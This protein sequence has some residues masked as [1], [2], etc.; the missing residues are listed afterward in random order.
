MS[1]IL[2]IIFTMTCLVSMMAGHAEALPV[3]VAGDADS[4]TAPAGMD[5]LAWK[6]LLAGEI[7]VESVRTD[8]AGGAARVKALS[9]G[10]SEALWAVIISCEDAFRFV[11]GM[12]ICNVL[13]DDGGHALVHQG[14]KQSWILPRLDFTFAAIRKPFTAI[15]FQ[16][17]EGDLRTMEGGWRFET[18]P[19]IDAVI[20]THEIRVVPQFPAPR[21][22][23]RR[24][25]GR[26]VP[27]ML[28]CIR[29]LAGGSGSGKQ[30]DLD[31]GS[32]RGPV[33]ESLK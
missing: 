3:P 19:E 1:R 6:Q 16:L 17:V 10:S 28:A 24:S 27:E 18:L 31:L 13:E 14:V 29:G 2:L 32:C 8:E 7:L 23:V 12:Q 33:R 4:S 11:R 15:D 25:I 20:V 26:D 22:L 21:W 30:Q 9:Y 5:Q